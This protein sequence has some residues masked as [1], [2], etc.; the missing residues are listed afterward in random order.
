MLEKK[1]FP[2]EE[3]QVYTDFDK[4]NGEYFVIDFWFIENI[5]TWEYL[6]LLLGK[7]HYH[8]QFQNVETQEWHLSFRLRSKYFNWHWSYFFD[9]ESNIWYW[10][11]KV[12]STDG[13]N[14]S[15]ELKFDTLWNAFFFDIDI[16]KPRP[17]NIIYPKYYD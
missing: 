8:M 2:F 1:D 11:I 12:F 14:K 7:N 13:A 9:D 10:E 5:Q 6:E 17:T 15:F 16:E 3:L 4:E